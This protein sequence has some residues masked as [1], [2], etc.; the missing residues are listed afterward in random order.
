MTPDR[1]DVPQLASVVVTTFDAPE[2]L[3]VCLRSLA[4]QTDRAF[5]AVVADD[6]SSSATARMLAALRGE[7]A[8]P[9]RHVRQENLGFRPARARNLAVG[10]SR[11]DYLVFIDGDCFVL[12]DFI[13]RHRALAR[14]RYFVTGKRSWLGRAESGRRLRGRVCDRR[15]RWLLRALAG[16]CTRPL[17]FVPLP[18]GRWRDRRSG[19]WRGAQTCNL[20][21]W[22]GDFAAVN[23][24][25]NRYAGHGLEDSDLA[26]RLLRGGVRRKLGSCASPVLHLWHERPAP[27]SASPNRRRFQATLDG[28]PVR[29]ADGLEEAANPHPDQSEHRSRAQ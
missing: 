17:E 14:R 11:G 18:D 28:G 3:R 15:W 23:G 27:A 19:D 9:L 29:A 5:E 20:G 25:D 8:F 16:R 26:A 12:P 21:V 24:F 10:A 13:A 7:L 1:D 4:R 6:G 2:A 22:R